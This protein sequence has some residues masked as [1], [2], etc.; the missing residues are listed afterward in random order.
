MNLP[1]IYSYTIL[2]A[3]SGEFAERTPYVCAILEDED[4]ERVSCVLGGWKE[5]VPVHIGMPI[6]E[7]IG[8]DGEVQFLL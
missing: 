3:P 4:G 5:N 7:N 1:R 6:K 2:R 8:T